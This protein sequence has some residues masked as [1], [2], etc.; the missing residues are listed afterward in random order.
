MSLKSDLTKNEYRLTEALSQKGFE[1]WRHHFTGINTHTLEERSFFVEYF[2][3][4]PALS[5]ARPVLGQSPSYLMVKAG[6]WGEEA[7]Q[8]HRFFSWEDVSIHEQ[9][10]VSIKA[11][12]CLLSET[13]LEGSVN[14]S[15]TGLKRRSDHMCDAGSLSWHLQIKKTIPFNGDFATG[16][17]MRTTG[18][19]PMYHHAEGMKA[20]Y[21][22]SIVLDGQE[23][24]V[25]PASSFGYAAK[26]WGTDFPSPWLWLSSCD[27]LSTKTG[28]RLMHSAFEI[29]GTYRKLFRIPMKKKLLGA[30]CYENKLFEFHFLK[31]WTLPRFKYYCRETADELIWHMRLESLTALLKMEVHCDKKDMLFLNYESPE[32]IKKHNRLFSGGTGTGYIRLYRKQ[33]SNKTLVD[34]VIARHVSCGYGVADISSTATPTPTTE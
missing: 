31:F 20:Q 4:N 3:C 25:R 14:I 11:D 7:R 10:P 18:A 5:K 30:F 8:V 33:G 2:L 27:L 13:Y 9:T 6:C 24:T 22:G 26:D 32:G 19:L 12:N 16:K 15:E 23:Y 17:F 29:G 1:L 34:E 28:D 21:E